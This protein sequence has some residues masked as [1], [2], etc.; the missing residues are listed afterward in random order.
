[1]PDPN[2]NATRPYEWKP[3]PPLA[4]MPPDLEEAARAIGLSPVPFA[5]RIVVG[6]P[7]AVRRAWEHEIDWEIYSAAES[8]SWIEGAAVPANP[9]RQLVDGFL[10]VNGLCGMRTPT[11]RQGLRIRSL[12]IPRLYA[13][14]R[15]NGL[16]VAKRRSAQAAADIE[17][18]EVDLPRTITEFLALLGREVRPPRP[19]TDEVHALPRGRR[20]MCLGGEVLSYAKATRRT[21]KARK[22][23]GLRSREG[24]FL[25]SIVGRSAT[26]VAEPDV[27]AHVRNALR[28]VG[29]E[30]KTTKDGYRLTPSLRWRDE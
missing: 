24:L 30:L 29:V 17:S 23:F 27:V 14:C 18:L 25:R 4:P 11:R 21:Q 22:S 3:G 6:G 19:G 12:L 2:A 8:N 10:A 1:M 15:T 16:H 20:L 28:D 13:F 5:G 7:Y 9:L 26:V